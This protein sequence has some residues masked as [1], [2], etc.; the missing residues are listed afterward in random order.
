MAAIPHPC[1]AH[2]NAFS[3]KRQTKPKAVRS[4][5]ARLTR[6]MRARGGEELRLRDGQRQGGVERAA[7]PG[8]AVDVH[9]ST[10]RL[11]QA[12]NNG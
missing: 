11:Y 3:Y 1:P 6:P 2:Y 7:L 4:V 5:G 8:R 10:V 12:A 9:F